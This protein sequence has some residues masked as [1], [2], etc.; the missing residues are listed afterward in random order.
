M[1]AIA[2]NFTDANL[3]NANLRGLIGSSLL[4]NSLSLT[5]RLTGDS[6]QAY[7]A[8]SREAAANFTGANLAGTN[9]TGSFL[10]GATFGGLDLAA[11]LFKGANLESVIR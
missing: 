10:R 7:L 9:F 11:A 2:T 8:S 4:D 1:T 5:Q 6:L 3:S